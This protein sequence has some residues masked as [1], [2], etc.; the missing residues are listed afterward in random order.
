MNPPI[1][2][3]R[4]AAETGPMRDPAFDQAMYQVRFEWGAAG[5]DRL[6]P[7]DVVVVLDVLR[8]TTTVTVRAERSET[9][10]LHNAPSINGAP[11][12]A[13]AATVPG[14]VVLAGSL[15]HADAVA[16]EILR[17]Q[18]RRDRRTSVAVIAAGEAIA[19]GDP[20]LRF[21]VEDQLGAGA[22]IDALIRRGIDHVSP[23]AMLTAESFRSLRGALRHL[24]SAS[25]AA[26]H[27]RARPEQYPDAEADIRLAA[28]LDSSAAVAE[29]RGGVF[30][31]RTHRDT[32]QR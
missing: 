7:A 32:S 26:R 3:V 8:F 22:V 1:G 4:R 11:V 24:V 29:L 10:P 25:G 28:E 23:E 27:L 5:L 31:P 12:A 6:A 30:T 18:V 21:A 13:A 2:A 16:E 20:R 17:E 9:T 19:S 14:A 15:R